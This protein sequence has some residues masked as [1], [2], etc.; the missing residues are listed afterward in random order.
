MVMK[1]R[2]AEFCSLLQRRRSV[3]RFSPQAVPREVIESC[4]LAAGS[5]PSGANRQP[6]RFV[7]VGDEQVK[8][9]IRNAAEREEY[10][11]YRRVSIGGYPKLTVGCGPERVHTVSG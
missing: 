2:A 9:E 8:K 4:L 10:E 6:W 5:A 7:V 3:R 11:F 1:K